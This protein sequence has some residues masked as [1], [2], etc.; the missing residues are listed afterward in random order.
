[1]KVRQEDVFDYN[2]RFP[3]GTMEGN[4]TERIIQQM[5]KDKQ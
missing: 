5:G 3:D 1:V 2:R 4:E